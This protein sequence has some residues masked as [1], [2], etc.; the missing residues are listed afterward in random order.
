MNLKQTINKLDEKIKKVNTK[1]E[2]NEVLEIIKAYKKPFIYE[3]NKYFLI[4][5]FLILFI[6]LYNIYILWEWN[7]QWGESNS[8]ALGLIVLLAIPIYLILTPLLRN[9]KIRNIENTIYKIDMMLDNNIKKDSTISHYYL[10]SNY[11]GFNRGNYQ[12][13]LK[14]TYIISNFQAN[15]YLLEA[16]LFNYHYVN[17]RTETYKCGKSTCTRTVY[18]HYNKYGIE[19][20]FKNTSNIVI[21]ADIFSVHLPQTFKTSS[22]KFN[23]KFQV[24]CE[25]EFTAV[26]FLQPS[27]IVYFEDLAKEFNYLSFQFINNKLCIM[28][29]NFDV[30]PNS[31][32]RKYGL[33]SPKEFIE[34]LNGF[35]KIEK[36]SKLLNAVDYMLSQTDNNFK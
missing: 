2:L 6:L 31:A 21:N 18:D 24:K 15:T 1:E 3:N 36:L 32:S 4:S 20:D 17:K 11:F 29:S 14:E 7:E 10:N 9:M 25:D 23:K 16:K 30:L 34:E 13:K 27:L 8:L 33:T 35:T 28:F 22:I 19:V 5:G 26:K 12:N